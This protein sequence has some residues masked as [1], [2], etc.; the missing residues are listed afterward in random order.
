MMTEAQL[1][2]LYGSSSAAR[3]AAED[4]QTLMIKLMIHHLRYEHNM[5]LSVIA[6]RLGIKMAKVKAILENK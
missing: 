1:Y 6:R 4:A 5:A 2:N 3:G